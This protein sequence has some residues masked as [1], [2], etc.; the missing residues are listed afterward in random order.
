MALSSVYRTGQRFGVNYVID[1]LLARDHDRIKSNGHDKVSTFGI[2]SFLSNT[3]WHS[4]F[5]QLIALGYLNSDAESYGALK[6]TQVSKPLLRGEEKL[7]L[8]KHLQLEKND[9]TGNEKKTSKQV[10][11]GDQ[12]LFEALRAQRK[13]LAEQQ[14]VP[15]FV[16]LHDKTLHDLCN[17]RPQSTNDLQD[18][19]GIGST[20]LSLYGNDLLKIIQQYPLD[21]TLDNSLSNTINETLLMFTQGTEIEQ[22][23]QH[24]KLSLTT[25]YNHLGAAIDAGILALEQVIKLDKE[26][27]DEIIYSMELA[28]SEETFSMKNVFD[29]L[30]EKYNYHILNCVK[31]SLHLDT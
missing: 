23:A 22:I 12:P 5:R 18:I 3:E 20:K 6:L 2:G 29:S 27:L 26:Q 30:D 28:N 14:G 13:Q 4:V 24:R 15:P 25:V 7:E 19:T 10:R 17:K 31:A 9:I 21:N 8:R 11:I 16:I 1:V